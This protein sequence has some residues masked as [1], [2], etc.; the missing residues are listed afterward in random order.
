[1][2]L[3]VN[4][5]FFLFVLS[6]AT[7]LFN[8]GCDQNTALDKVIDSE[9][10]NFFHSS[11]ESYT[12]I[13]VHDIFSPP[14]ASRNY[15]YPFLAAYETFRLINRDSTSTQIVSRLNYF[16]Q[17]LPS[18]I[19]E[20]TLSPICVHLAFLYTG[21]HF[22]FS[23][24]KVILL[25]DE[26]KRFYSDRN[27]SARQIKKAE[28]FALQMSEIMIQYASEDNY[29]QS[30]TFAKFTINDDPSTW[31]P[32]P[33]AYMQ[34][35]EP[36]WNSI[37]PFLM[38]RP[39]QFKPLPPTPFDLTEGSPFYIEVMEV[40]NAVK[41]ATEEQIEI[42]NFWDCNPY[43]MNITGHVMHATKKIT[44]GGHWMNIVSIVARDLQ[45][46]IYESLK[47]YAAVSLALFEGFISCWDE[48]YRSILIR[49]ESVINDYFDEN[50]MPLLQTPPF[51]EYTSGHSVI[52]TAAA[53]VLTVMLGDSISFVDDTEVKYG[54]PIRNFQSF[55]HA[56]E[57]A[58]I[59]RLYGGIH[60]SPAIVNG[61][62]QGKEIGKL[63]IEKL[64]LNYN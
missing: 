44:P 34:G 47:V 2:L 28:S 10:V 18:T 20:A 24:E 41:N 40:Y 26:V 58:A 35:I 54:L 37:R 57:E 14:V 50:W 11:V 39:D 23:E 27:V 59:S 15:V 53:E 19:P 38:D 33:P 52:S 49:P 32:T 45:L 31:K 16:N 7:I 36:S 51:P 63:V 30:R 42:A 13:I 5:I 6:F 17:D 21:K 29:K 43:K 64:G 22:V 9:S 1:M 8:S 55:R 48:K 25:I 46:G 62:K 4:R 3:D 12:D 60:Y 56:A 61:Q